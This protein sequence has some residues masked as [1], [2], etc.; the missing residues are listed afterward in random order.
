MGQADFAIRAGDKGFDGVA[1]LVFQR[2]RFIAQI[3]DVH[4]RLAATTKVD[5]RD[6]GP[7]FAD[8]A[9]DFFPG[10]DRAISLA[11]ALFEQSGKFRARC[12]GGV[13][14]VECVNAI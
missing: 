10:R 5:K 7:D 4:R 13:L 11:V 9:R 3:L 8:R 6:R 1:G 14:F 12:I 2:A